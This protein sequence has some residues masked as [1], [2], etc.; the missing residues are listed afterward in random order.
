[1][2]DRQKLL[3]LTNTDIIFKNT[4][5]GKQYAEILIKGGKTRPRTIPLIDS[6]PY[7][8][9]LICNH[10]SGLNSDSW[11]F[12]SKSNTA[13]GS[14]LT[15]DGITYQYKYFY[16]TKLF[17][18]LIDDATVPEVDKAFNQK[19]NYKKW[20]IYVQ[21]QPNF[22]GKNYVIA[23]YHNLNKK[24]YLCMKY[25]MACLLYS[26]RYILKF[27]NFRV[28]DLIEINKV[29]GLFGKITN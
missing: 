5:E 18:K 13:F 21:R 17:P 19:F 9:D 10:P 29:Q 26:V 14:K 1:M 15:L 8:K 28:K 11:L 24:W 22:D 12:I 23:I 25:V 4:T 2:P 27:H 20:N 6:I 16:N 3:N 7:V